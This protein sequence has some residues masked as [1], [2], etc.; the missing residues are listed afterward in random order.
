MSKVQELAALFLT[1]F[2]LIYG[3]GY[4]YIILFT[5]MIGVAEMAKALQFYLFLY[6][7]SK[8]T[9]STLEPLKYYV[10]EVK[11]MS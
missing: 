10:A 6:A 1:K 11:C 4:K 9:N 3:F 2:K 8:S 7:E 5:N